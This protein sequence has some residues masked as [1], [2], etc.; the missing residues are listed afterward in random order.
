MA[1]LQAELQAELKDNKFARWRQYC[2]GL[3]IVFEVRPLDD[4]HDCSFR[5]APKA[6]T[7]AALSKGYGVPYTRTSS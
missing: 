4:T 1:E 3:L 5:L 7:H 2:I 6:G